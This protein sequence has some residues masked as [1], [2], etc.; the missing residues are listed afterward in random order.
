MTSPSRGSKAGIDNRR[1]IPIEQ[2]KEILNRRLGSSNVLVA[3]R[4]SG[5]MTPEILRRALD[6]LQR[7]HPRLRSTIEGPDE[8]LRFK[9]ERAAPIPLAVEPSMGESGDL[10]VEL[11]EINRPID[12]RSCL[13]RA[14][15]LQPGTSGASC[16]LILLAHHAAIDGGSLLELLEDLVRFCR[17]LHAGEPMQ[18]A[19]VEPLALL[20]SAHDL[21]PAG[22]R[23]LRGRV[24]TWVHGLRTRR[25]LRR[26]RARTLPVERLVPPR[27]RV[28][29]VVRRVLD[30]DR[31]RRL[32]ARCD[33][34][35]TSMHGLLCA[36][37]LFAV[38]RRLHA[39]GPGDGVPL[40]CRTSVNLRQKLQPAVGR[41][42]LGLFASFLL[43]FHR[44]R[45]DT[46]LDALAT[47][48]LEQ[49]WLG[50]RNLDMFR[51]LRRVTKNTEAALRGRI[52]VTVFVTSV[53]ESGI[54]VDHGPFRIEEV[55][56]LPGG[57]AVPGVVGLASLALNDRLALGFFFSSPALS[58][59][60]VGEIADDMVGCLGRAS[61]GEV[62]FGDL[63]RRDGPTTS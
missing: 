61:E 1:L 34:S 26:F 54:A 36:A 62:R 51:S 21:M 11:R 24:G 56:G 63:A 32:R 35:G 52:P 3:S 2:S 20:P 15:L 28:S 41:K 6:L 4:I 49:L 57:A 29:G 50:Y 27:E 38:A 43:T 8:D 25:R 47:E 39:T 17:R 59:S 44:L 53:G 40:V 46:T 13:L 58:E 19:D 45:P 33:E 14:T 10:A 18:G 48:V 7:R 23:S 5:P 12:S 22:L 55:E 37:L 16:R 31:L 42:D 9:D 30:A 60:T